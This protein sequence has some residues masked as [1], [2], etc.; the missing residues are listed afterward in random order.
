MV[1]EEVILLPE[2]KVEGMEAGLASLHLTEVDPPKEMEGL[3]QADGGALELEVAVV[4][5][6]EAVGSHPAGALVVD[7]VEVLRLQ[8]LRTTEGTPAPVPG[9]A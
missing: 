2:A 9:D 3:R 4:E 6:A 1:A 7:Q 8:I 5:A